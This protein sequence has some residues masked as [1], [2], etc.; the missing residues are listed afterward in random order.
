VKTFSE[1]KIQILRST[2]KYRVPKHTG[3]SLYPTLIKRSGGSSSSSDTSLVVELVASSSSGGGSHNSQEVDNCNDGK[4]ASISASSQS[5]NKI[6]QRLKEKM[7]ANK[8]QPGVKKRIRKN[9]RCSHEG[10]SNQAVKG[11]VCVTHGAKVTKKQ[12]SFE[13]CICMLGGKEEYV[14]HMD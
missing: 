7:V 3:L 11:G 5:K 1:R 6:Q 9:K 12:C 8:S 13:G 14:S 4:D 10:C 2:V